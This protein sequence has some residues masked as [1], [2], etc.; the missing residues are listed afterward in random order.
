MPMSP[1]SYALPLKIC[2]PDRLTHVQLLLPWNPSPLQSSR[3]PLEY[4]LLPPRSALK[5][6]PLN[7]TFI[8][9]LS[10]YTLLSGFRL[11]WPPCGCLDELTPFVVSDKCIFRH[12]NSAFGSSHIASS[13]YQKWPT[14]D[15][16]S[17]TSSIKKQGNFGRNQLLDGSISLSPLYPDSTIDLHT[18][19]CCTLRITSE[20]HFHYAFGFQH[21][22]TRKHV[23]LL[24]PCFKTGRLK[25]FHQHPYIQ[26]HVLLTLFSKFFSSFPHGTCLLSVSHLYLALDGIY[27]PL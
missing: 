9:P 11:P 18:G 8:R 2:I 3:I 13:A 23:R 6:A 14:K 17:C 12:L 21:P 27:H 16:Y 4:L 19:R 26:F 5:A 20:I 1:S 7:I 22:N 10:C 24:G 15:F 25:L